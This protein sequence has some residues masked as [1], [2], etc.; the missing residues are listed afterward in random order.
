MEIC[1][2]LHVWADAQRLFKY[3]FE[4]NQI[5]LNGLYV[6]FEEGE[7]A[8]GGR[9]IV[10]IGSHTGADQLGSRLCQ[11]FV[12][13]NKDRSIF[14]K[15]IGR[16][17]LNRDQDPFLSFWDLDLTTR[18]MRAAHPNIDS[19]R[20]K[21][22][23]QAVSNYMQEKFKFV[24]LAVAEKTDRLA[25][26]S[27]MISTVAACNKC[28]PSTT[29]LGQYSPIKKIRESGLWLVNHLSGELL[30]EADLKKLLRCS[31]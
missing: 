15:N 30:S 7:V 27:K 24:V 4:P 9:R 18:R 11:H 6:L 31:G 21:E 29:W 28:S 22:I 13:P 2:A 3:P 25:L 23:E 16:A 14:R 8:H 5:P 10:R 26:E 1:E 20:Q 19:I 17:L 12:K